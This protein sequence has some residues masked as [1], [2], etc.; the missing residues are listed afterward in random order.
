[1]AN[2]KVIR[3][4]VAV[5]NIPHQISKLI[6]LVKGIVLAMTGNANFPTPY[7]ANV[8]AL[9]TVTAD[10]NAL[11]STES[12][13]LTKVI[14]SVE[15]RDAKKEI[16]LKDLHA[17]L[18]YVQGIADNNPANAVAIIKSAGMDVKQPVSR[19]KSDFDVSY[20]D[21]SGSALLVAKVAAKRASYEW[22]MSADGKTWNNLPVTLICKTTVTGLVPGTT[23]YFRFKAVTTD[24]EGDWSQFVSI[25]AIQQ[26]AIIIKQQTQNKYFINSRRGRPNLSHS[27]PS[28]FQA[29]RF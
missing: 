28:S 26:Q 27:G 25:V 24:G 14:G 19:T 8:P 4:E 5:L 7:P 6:S 2:K 1:M 15:T 10:I 11:D 22:Q 29:G 18:A 21:V 20:G 12:V 3:R 13:A 17:L 16:L 23:Y 9:A